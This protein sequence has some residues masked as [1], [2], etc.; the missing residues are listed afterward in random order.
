MTS[1]ALSS[2]LP[3]PRTPL[4]GRDLALASL[5]DLF[6]HADVR[7]LTLTGVGG[8]G[9]TRLAL[10]LATDLVPAFNPR[11]WLVELAPVTD[12][13]LV[14][15]AVAD[16]L[17]LRGTEGKTSL[18]IVTSFLAPQPALLVLDNCEHLIDAC[19]ALT[20]HL[21]ATCPELHIIA[22]SRESFQIAG[23]RQYRV[24]PLALPDT[25][26]LPDRD[27]FARSPAVQLFVARAQAVAPAF[28]L[29]TENASVIGEICKRLDGIPL[30]IELA[31][32]RTRVLAVQEILDRLEDA[33]RLLVGGNRAGPTRQQ[34]LRATLDWSDALLTASERAV[35]RRLGVFAGAFTLAAVEAVCTDEDVPADD[36]L[37]TL[38][39][40]VDKSLV[41][42]DGGEAVTWYRLL[43]PVRQYA[44]RELQAHGEAESARARYATFALCLAEEAASALRGPRQD[45]WLVRLEREQG[46]LRAAL[47]WAQEMGAWEVGLRLATALVPFW[48]AHGHLAEGRR[49]LDLAL[50][51]PPGTVP[52]TLRMRALTGAGRLT[53]FHGAYT[54][55][56]RLHTESLELARALGD[57]HGI[58][59]ALTELGMVARR[60]HDQA[61]S[62]AYLDEGMAIFRARG[63]DAGI[64]LALF[65]IGC[66]AASQMIVNIGVT[67]GTVGTQPDSEGAVP[68]LTEALA[69]FEALGDLRWI[70]VAQ[71]VL[72]NALTFSGE[73]EPA[74]RYLVA[75]LAGHVRLGDRWFITNSLVAMAELHLARH[76]WEVAARLLGAAQGLGEELS[77]K[78]SGITYERLGALTGAH[79]DAD[80]FTAAWTA[81]H[82][83]TLD[84]ASAEALGTRGTGTTQST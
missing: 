65:N 75:G 37:E 72:G 34:T 81:G 14:P 68:L 42:V 62:A 20:D 46:T 25:D 71:S 17:S 6:L 74:T 23:E 12:S 82:A 32:A 19:A 56:E 40:L 24:A 64:A 78:I 8:C 1:H 47:S 33:F 70:A 22:T 4:V 79:L 66:T 73:L 35:F 80:R 31:A 53:H 13:A 48:D 84:Q 15:I 63:D 49:W 83:L 76:Q 7:L 38:T 11:I 59:T 61:R 9:K 26:R 16:A 39:R 21:L 69:H 30:A 27:T 54:E 50:A 2:P 3:I 5:H 28:S 18:D 67:M 41:V 36:L 58:A 10:Q 51:A 44:L 45:I 43:E 52:P 29:T 55:A 77:S 60:Q 57:E